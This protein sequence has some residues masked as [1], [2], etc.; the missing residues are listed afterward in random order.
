MSRMGKWLCTIVLIFTGMQVSWAQLTTTGNTVVSANAL[1]NNI[2]GTGVTFSNATY[3]GRAVA[4]GTFNGAASNIGLPSGVIITSGHI[5]VAPGPNNNGGATFS[6]NGPNIPELETL[7]QST[8][9]DGAILEFDFVPQSNFVSFRYVF[10]SEEYNEYVCSEFNDAFAF[11]ISGPGI[12]GTENLAVVPSTTTPVTINTIN[13]GSVGALGSITNSP[14]VLT[15]SGYFVGNT[16]N[17]VQYDGWTTVLTAQRT[18]VPCQTYHIRMM[19]ADGADDIFDSAVFLEENSFSSDVFAVNVSTFFNDSTIYEG[20]TSADITFSRPDPDPTPLTVTYTVSG[21]ATMGT[22]F[23]PLS[24]SVTIP[25]GQ[26]S[27]TVTVN[28]F[29]DGVNEG[30]ETIILN[31]NTPCGTI[32][33]IIFL[34]EKPPLSV[35][36]PNNAICSGQGP[37]SLTATPQGG[38]PPYSYSWD[39]GSTSNSISVNPSTTTAYTVVVTDFCGTTAMAQPVVNI[40]DIPTA[41]ISAPPFICSGV[42]V[43]VSYTGTASPAATYNWDFDNPSS[44]SSG[45]DQGPYQVSWD[46]AGVKTISLQVIE[47]GCASNTVTTQVLVN[48]TPTADFVVDPITCSGQNTTITY[49]GTGTDAGGYGWGFPGGVIITGGR[50]GPFEIRW[51]SVGVYGVTLTVTENGCTSPGNEVFVNVLPTPTSDFSVETP[52]CVGQPST[53]SYDGNASSTA[54]YNWNFAGGTIQSGTG[55]GPY[56]IIW[57]TSGTKTVF[58]SVT[59]AGCTSNITSHDVVVNGIPQANFTVASPVCAGQPTTATYS[60]N[61]NNNANYNWDFGTATVQTGSGQ[62]PY[63]L[64]WDNPGTYNVSLVVTR[65]GCSSPPFSAP[66]TVF[67]IPSAP[68]T[69]ESPVCVGE[70]STIGYTG[71]LSNGTTFTWDFSGGQLLSGSGSGPYEVYWSSPGTKQITFSLTSPEGCPSPPNTIPVIVNPTPSST[72]TAE[73]P[74]CLNETS[75]INYTGTGNPGAQYSWNFNGGIVMSGGGQGPYEIQWQT[76]GIKTITVQVEEN[77]CVSPPTQQ[78]VNVKPLPTGFFT[79]VTPVCAFNTTTIVYSGNAQAN[80]FFSWDFDNGVIVSGS[81]PGPI[82]VYWETPGPKNIRLVVEEDGCESIEEVNVVNVNPIPQNSF[83]ATS[84]VCIGEPSTI[85]YTGNAFP[86]ANY[87]WNFG[88]G[89]VQSGSGDGPFEV[90]W[91]TAGPKTITLDLSQFGCPAPQ[92]TQTVQVNP[93]PDSPF[94]VDDRVCVGSPATITYTGTA[95]LLGTYN[96][97]FDGGIIVS[98][99]GSGPFEVMWNTPGVKNITLSVVE[100]GCPSPPTV[101]Q[102]QV[103]PYPTS[104]FVANPLTCEGYATTVTFT[105][106]AMN[107]ATFDWNFDGAQVLSGSGAGPYSVSWP[108]EGTKT[109]TLTVN[110]FGCESPESQVVLDVSPTPESFAGDDRIIC[111]GD[112][113]Q[114]GGLSVNGYAYQWTPPTGLS[115]PTISNPELVLQNMTNELQAFNYILATTLG[116]CTAYDTMTVMVQPMPQV[117]WDAPEGQCLSG[118][119]F[120]FNMVGNYSSNATINWSFGQFANPQSSSIENPSGIEFLTTGVH[121]ITVS[122]SDWGCNSPTYTDSVEIFAMPVA[123]FT[124][125]NLEGCPPLS[126]NFINLSADMGNQTFNWAMGDGF[127]YS[128]FVP[129]HSYETSGNYTVTLTVTTENGCS[130]SYEAHSM[131]NVYPV[132]QAGFEVNPEILTT[133]LPLATITDRSGG[134]IT[135]EYDLGDGNVS[136]ERNLQHNYYVPGEYSLRQMVTN[137]YG[138]VAYAFKTLKVEPVM[139]FYIPNAFTP[140]GDGTNEI[141]KCYGL[142]IEEFRMEIY[143][144]WGE[145]VFESNDIDYGWNGKL[146]NESDRPMSQMDVYAVVVYVRDNLDLPPRRI[147]HRVTLVR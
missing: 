140:D 94:T 42:Q 98:G 118:N 45:S 76:P 5:N 29:A 113:I 34:R 132:P 33:Q 120:E 22:D 72:F 112:T 82:Q 58:L 99:T 89:I 18:V 47:N 75:T 139:T 19:I 143:D 14:C 100:N 128:D 110:Q 87:T 103:I 80:A 117:A 129:N 83:T 9:F 114:I 13:N 135:W 107:E 60:G 15:N 30:T 71:T 124:G 54:T 3:T 142:N 2:I 6:N 73:T 119:S 4:V 115:N 61:A 121:V 23:T 68:F 39:N 133:A 91:E 24:G 126:S 69:V 88:D 90:I 17:T 96:W 123:N 109:I 66:V 51:D 49:T 21:T 56:E 108:V 32:P 125:S 111:P 104:D 97:N 38:I 43:T 50:R 10:A 11:F 144:R 63:T 141:F 35:L 101:Q 16:S 130:A 138:C 37:V 12:T 146:F 145:L 81:G 7:A 93:I 84:P 86:T 31:A 53:I 147:D 62:G 48:P 127:N 41:S 36:A 52:V 106:T 122:V 44:V 102:I 1:V 92:T 136:Y 26:T 67:A 20:C 64:Q 77:G 134:A 85:V 27:T 46:S 137:Q 95:S 105:G 79:A 131:V 70:G 55:A 25:A 59:E 28:G 116:N 65:N 57:N 78:Q 74:I 40:A 8:T